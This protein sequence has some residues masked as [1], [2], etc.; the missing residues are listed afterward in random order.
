MQE[1][2]QKIS[3]HF[4]NEFISD[5]FTFIIVFIISRMLRF[6]LFFDEF[7]LNFNIIKVL[8]IK[9]LHLQC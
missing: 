6:I 7:T 5:K 1:L 2:K 9:C 4:P 3:K 8:K